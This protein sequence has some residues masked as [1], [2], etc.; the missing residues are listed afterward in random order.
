MFRSL[1]ITCAS[2]AAM[3]A[4]SSP[5]SAQEPINSPAAT[6]PS[7][8]RWVVRDQLKYLE[9]R[10]HPDT[11]DRGFRQFSNR[12]SIAYGIRNDL[13]AT[14]SVPLHHRRFRSGDD[15]QR[16]NDFGLGDVTAQL[17][18][19]LYQNDFGPIDT[20][21]FSLLTSVQIP[22]FDRPFSSESVNPG[23]G[24]VLTHV[25]GRHGFNVSGVY[26]LN[27]GTGTETNLGGGSGKADAL[28]YDAS[29]L[30]RLDPAQYTPESTGALYGVVEFNGLYETNGDNELFISPGLMYEARTWTIEAAIQVPIWQDIDRRPETRFAAVLGLRLLF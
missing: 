7:T 11:D 5:A 8:G 26:Q 27:T 21:R 4:V 10:E 23:I 1:I 25:Q 14:F 6:Q 13:A 12:I 30:F 9:A 28:S 15:G 22:S 3:T 20:T 18:W 24:G 2:V 29:Y 19:R 16:D 17:K